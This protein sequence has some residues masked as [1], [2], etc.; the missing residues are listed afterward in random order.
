MPTDGPTEAM[1]AGLVHG[2]AIGIVISQG[3]K[4]FRVP[5]IDGTRRRQPW[6]WTRELRDTNAA[7]L[8]V[9]PASR[10]LLALP[11][12]APKLSRARI[13][14]VLLDIAVTAFDLINHGVATTGTVPTGPFSFGRTVD[15]ARVGG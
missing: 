14:V 13:A 1:M 3:P 11:S 6:G 2:L 9:G 15:S 7:T 4:E 8:R 10:G 5:G 12:V